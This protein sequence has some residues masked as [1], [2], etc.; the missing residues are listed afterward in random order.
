[1]FEIGGFIP[2]HFE[3]NLWG[4]TNARA[5]HYDF[6]SFELSDHVRG[7]RLPI[8]EETCFDVQRTA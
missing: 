4:V 6:V 5:E 3:R 7:C 1:M 2:E 8:D